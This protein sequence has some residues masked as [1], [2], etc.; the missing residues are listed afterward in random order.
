MHTHTHTLTHTRYFHAPHTVPPA[1]PP[2]QGATAAV[3]TQ[4]VTGVQESGRT[5]HVPQSGD[6]AMHRVTEISSSVQYRRLI[7]ER[8]WAVQRTYRMVGKFG[9]H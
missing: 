8:P 2:L 5:C 9:G 4:P 1:A 6:A 7:N 3:P